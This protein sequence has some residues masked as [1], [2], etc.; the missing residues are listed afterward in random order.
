MERNLIWLSLFVLFV[1]EGAVLPPLIP[2]WFGYTAHVNVQ[3]V[4]VG[5]MLIGIF[6]NRHSALLYGICFGFMHDL[7][8]GQMLGVSAFALGLTGYLLGLLFASKYDTVGRNLSVMFVGLLF[9]EAIIVLFYFAF[10]IYT[11]VFSVAF[12]VRE[13]LPAWTLSFLFTLAIYY[14]ARHI[15]QKFAVRT[16]RDLR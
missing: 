15:L 16:G 12:F 14:P 1:M 5:V 3:L 11:P 8:Y 6:Y 13:W 9:Y 4:L 2:D 10:N 7:I